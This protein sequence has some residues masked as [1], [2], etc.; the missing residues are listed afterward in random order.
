MNHKL[1]EKFYQVFF[2]E[3]QLWNGM[4]FSHSN[5][6]SHENLHIIRPSES[7]RRQVEKTEKEFGVSYPEEF[8][9]WFGMYYTEDV[10]CGVLHLPACP[11]EN[12]TRELRSY[13][14]YGQ[15]LLSEHF[16]PFGYE[17][18]DSGEL[19]FDQRGNIKIQPIVFWEHELSP[20]HPKAFTPLFSSF[21]AMIEHLIE[22]LYVFSGVQE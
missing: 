9:D 10:D 22:H 17:G 12:P 5:T 20:K 6:S 13:L 3:R 7:V 8:K 18:N 1:Y 4:Y 15:N 19:C 21:D 11:S 16:L 2:K 14:Q